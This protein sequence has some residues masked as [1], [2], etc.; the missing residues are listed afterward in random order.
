MPML[1]VLAGCFFGTGRNAPSGGFTDRDFADE[2]TF[3]DDTT[4]W[5]DVDT[6]LDTDA[7]TDRTDTGRCTTTIFG[8]V[9]VRPTLSCEN[10]TCRG[11]LLVMLFDTPI[12]NINLPAPVGNVANP[13]IV[14]LEDGPIPF[15]IFGA[16][17]GPH[18]VLALLDVDQDGIPSSGDLG[19]VPTTLS[20][21]GGYLLES[22]VLMFR[23]P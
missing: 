12:T 11:G 19:H 3:E 18:Q 7:D 8:D 22:P 6:D 10:Q 13:G 5:G 2:F 17:C 16:P 23:I 15:E 1:L 20:L 21:A 4:D 9:S 14:D